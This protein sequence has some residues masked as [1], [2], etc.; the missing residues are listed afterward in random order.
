MTER[1]FVAVCHTAR[2]SALAVLLGVLFPW[3]KVRGT[4]TYLSDEGYAVTSLGSSVEGYE[5]GDGILVFLLGFAAIVAIA[6]YKNV[7]KLWA[8]V[9]ASLS[10]LAI[11][12]VAIADMV[13]LQRLAGD[14]PGPRDVSVQFGLYTVLIASVILSAATAVLVYEYAKQNKAGQ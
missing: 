2:F 5:A 1:A 10:S 8:L 11:N 13:V 14:W 9:V 7:E 12:A 4:I 6:V 3:V